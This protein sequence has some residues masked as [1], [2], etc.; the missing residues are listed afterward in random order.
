MAAAL[1]PG[2]QLDPNSYQQR[3]TYRLYNTI[4]DS[5]SDRV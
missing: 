1:L 3:A 4:H 5:R 2:H